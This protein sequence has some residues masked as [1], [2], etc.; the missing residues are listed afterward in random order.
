MGDLVNAHN[1]GD[2]V[3]AEGHVH[4]GWFDDAAVGFAICARD[5][6]VGFIAGMFW[7]NTW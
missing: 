2:R 7:L 1:V 4:V 5:L 3:T 6:G